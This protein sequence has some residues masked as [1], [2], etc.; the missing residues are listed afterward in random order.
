MQ[1][2]ADEVFVQEEIYRYVGQLV[3]RTRTHS[4]IDL[5]ISPRG[6]IHILQMA[7][8]LAFL[9]QRDYVVPEDIG[10]VFL[11]VCVHRIML[12]AKART[13]H[14]DGEQILGEILKEI[15][16]PGTVR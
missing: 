4:M 10:D 13:A 3:H 1:K 15:S 16:L 8:S 2:K 14:M 7:K 12:N 9:R 6:A 11:C 5:G